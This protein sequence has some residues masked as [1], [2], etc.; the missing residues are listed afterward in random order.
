MWLAFDLLSVLDSGPCTVS[1]HHV[2]QWELSLKRKSYI[3]SSYV[4]NLLAVL[5]TI[6][7]SSADASTPVEECSTLLE[8]RYVH[9]HDV[10]GGY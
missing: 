10:F 8:P 6:G 7:G 1:L 9:E 4:R 2:R 3:A 5:G